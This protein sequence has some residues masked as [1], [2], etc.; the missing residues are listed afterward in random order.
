MA[1]LTENKDVAEID[2]AFS[3]RIENFGSGTFGA[4]NVYKG[5]LLA[6]DTSDDTVKPAATS[7]TL[8]ALG[9]AELD[10]T[11]G[12]TDSV[13][14][15]CGIFKFENSTAGDAIANADAGSDCYIVDDQ[16]VAKTDGGST[17]SVAGKVYKVSA[18]GV[19]VAVNPL[20]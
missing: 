15:R 4:A 3:Q 18:D 11:D 12:T 10:K 9:R 1:A 19:W 16:T 13:Q 8:I 20:V 7:T 2:S 5:A 14:A 17:R 6:Y